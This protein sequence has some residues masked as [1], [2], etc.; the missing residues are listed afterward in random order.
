MKIAII[1]WWAA[2]MMAAATILQNQPCNH[3]NNQ[4][5]NQVLLFEKNN[6][7][8]AKVRIS[9]WGRCNITTWITSTK[10]LLTKYPRWANFIEYS[11]RQFTPKSIYKWFENNWLPLQMQDDLRAFPAS[12]KWSD[13]VKTF[14]DIFEQYPENINIYTKTPINQIKKL[15]NGN[16]E[17]HANDDIYI[18][19]KVIITT[20]WSAYGHTWSTGDG[21]DLAG[22]LWHSIT[23][24]WPS[25]NSFMLSETHIYKWLQWLAYPSNIKFLDPETKQY[26]YIYGNIVRTHFGISGPGIFAVASHLAHEELGG[27][28][29]TEWDS[30]ANKENH[31]TTPLCNH[32]TNIYISYLNKSQEERKSEIEN[33]ISQ[34]PKKQIRTMLSWISSERLADVIIYISQIDWLAACWQLSKTQKIY[35][36]KL[37]SEWIPVTIA[38]RRPG[39]EFVTAWWVKNDEINKKTM[40][41]LICPWLYFAGEI[42]DVDGYTWWFNLTNCWA[43]GK[44]AGLSIQ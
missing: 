1:W 39:D 10:E 22:K 20:W 14:E 28:R 26:K 43:S 29:V 34:N 4:P 35:I 7:L 17:I 24:L 12:N 36:C 19:D 40:E 5:C 16:F 3:V 41:S 30:Y 9:W 44:L 37:L 42:I 33:Y 23:R 2:G 38:D 18:V 8:G 13:V 25:L 6:I 11:L 21:Y 27:Y 15:D 31:V 32:V